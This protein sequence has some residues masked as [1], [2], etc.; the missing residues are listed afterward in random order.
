[1]PT[2]T[3]KRKRFLTL[4]SALWS[5]LVLMGIGCSGNTGL[6]QLRQAMYDQPKYEPMEASSFF[7]DGLSSR[8]PVRGTVARG[9][10]R[11]DAHFYAGKVN[12]ELAETFPVAV[13]REV[14]ERGHARYDIFCSPCHDRAGTG[15]GMVVQRGFRQPPSFHIDRLREAPVGHFFDVMTSG[16]GA[17]YSYAS[18]IT[19][20]DRWAIAAYVRALQLSQNATLEDVPTGV[21]KRLEA[22]KNQ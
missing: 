13:T 6:E 12:G 16:Y 15:N 1:M 2:D 21:R 7:A 14:L 18:R 22:E 20:Q 4:R 3:S 9:Q 5:A 19:P 11:L 10:L 8:Q 17:M